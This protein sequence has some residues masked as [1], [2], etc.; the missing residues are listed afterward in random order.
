MTVCRLHYLKNSFVQSKTIR[1]KTKS[2]M[3]QT[4]NSVGTDRKAKALLRLLK[5]RSRQKMGRREGRNIR[6]GRQRILKNFWAS[7]VFLFKLN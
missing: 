3:K 7:S 2:F 5:E 1:E 6:Q 4:K